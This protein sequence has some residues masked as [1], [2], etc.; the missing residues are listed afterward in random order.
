MNPVFDIHSDPRFWSLVVTAATAL[1]LGWVITMIASRLGKLSAPVHAELIRRMRT[2]AVIIPTVSLPI[3]LG[4][5]ALAVGIILLGLLLFGEFAR[6]TGIQADRSLGF[7]LL[8]GFGV[9]AA[10]MIRQQYALLLFSAPLFAALTMAGGLWKDR[11]AGYLRR[12]GCANLGFMICGVWPAHLGFLAQWTSPALLLWMILAVELNDVFA[13]LSGKLLGRRA[14]CPN[15][16]PGKTR[17]GLIG[18]LVLTTAFVTLTGILFFG[19][20]PVGEVRLLVPLGLVLALTGTAG[21]LILS[22]IKRDLDLK[23]LAESLPGHGG[24]LDRCDSLVFAA[25][26]LALSL[27]LIE[28]LTRFQPEHLHAL[29]P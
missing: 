17:G 19:G 6:A 21:D 27:A 5:V 4:P 12:I 18:S 1:L 10:A 25:P 13:Y 20:E 26:V 2:W 9:I 7:A 22:S 28:R 16:S 24:L 29:L 3:L 23:D 8:V 14:L 11:P 15:T